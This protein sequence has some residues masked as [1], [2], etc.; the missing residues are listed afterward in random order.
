MSVQAIGQTSLQQHH[1]TAF[2]R[3]QVLDSCCV[4][5][6]TPCYGLSHI[7]V[8]ISFAQSTKAHYA[9]LSAFGQDKIWMLLGHQLLKLL[10]VKIENG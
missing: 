7:T 9:K 3:L 4:L 8:L 10:K 1:R 5:I 2:Q 6:H